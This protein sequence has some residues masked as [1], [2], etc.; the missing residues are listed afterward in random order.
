MTCQV[1]SWHICFVPKSVLGHRGSNETANTKK[2]GALVS[3]CHESKDFDVTK[4]TDF[5]RKIP[6]SDRKQLRRPGWHRL[7]AL[8]ISFHLMYILSGLY[9][10]AE[11]REREF[12]RRHSRF[13]AFTYGSP[14]KSQKRQHVWSFAAVKKHAESFET[15]PA[16]P[17]FPRRIRRA[18]TIGAKFEFE[19]PAKAISTGRSAMV[20]NARK[21]LCK[22]DFL[23]HLLAALPWVFFVSAW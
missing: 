5:A 10:S 22:L 3:P 15:T 4:L 16:S 9:A 18:F 19:F 6:L 12:K 2:S 7:K 17:I 8:L 21:W 11:N 23:Q 13:F 14:C 20:D 1:K